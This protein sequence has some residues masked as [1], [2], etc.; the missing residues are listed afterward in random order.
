M[1]RYKEYVYAVYSTGSFSAAADQ[2]FLSQPCLSAMVK[3][4][5]DHIGVPIFNRKTKPVSL[6]EYGAQY[7]SYIEKIQ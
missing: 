5:E 6:T 3:K 4:A 1:F 7:I 2:L